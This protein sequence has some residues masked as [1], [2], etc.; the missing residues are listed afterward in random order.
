MDDA[1]MV[2]RSSLHIQT[3]HNVDLFTF[4][5]QSYWC[6]CPSIQ[7]YRQNSNRNMTSTAVI[8]GHHVTNIV[9]QLTLLSAIERK[10]PIAQII[11]NQGDLPIEDLNL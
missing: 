6:A 5:F 9:A 1:N 8:S 11:L 10:A 4:E 2:Q 3:K 7:I